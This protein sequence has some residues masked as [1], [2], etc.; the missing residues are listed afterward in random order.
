MRP[1]I[2]DE[3]ARPFLNQ[4]P[5]YFVRDFLI[6]MEKGYKNVCL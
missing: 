2:Y 6:G 3:A 4:K 1:I 5:H